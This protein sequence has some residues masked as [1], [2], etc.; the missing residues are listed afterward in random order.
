[1]TTEKSVFIVIPCYNEDPIIRSV[2]EKIQKI[3]NWRI[4]IVD[5][6]SDTPVVRFLG[7][8][9]GVTILRHR[10][11]CGAGAASQTGIKYA[12]QKGAEFIV[13]MDADGQHQ[14]EEINS[15]L[16]PV[17]SGKYD[18][19]I[20]SRFIGDIKNSNVPLFKK[21][22]LKVAYL[23]TWFV[24]GIF[25][26]DSQNGFKALNRKAGSS[27]KF[28]F[29]RY[30]FCLE[31]IDLIKVNNLKCC[32]VPVTVKYTDYSMAKGQKLSNSITIVYNMFSYKLVRIF[33]G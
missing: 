32:E 29:N 27:M 33:F 1:M 24:S 7:T 10:A 16:E 22:A 19:A 23:F 9:E 26:T 12:L 31:I 13:L 5:D 28:L 18:I 11:N 21:L 20:G 30:E 8:L 4:V 17:K 2:I 15:I 3:A 14:P 6:A 25:V